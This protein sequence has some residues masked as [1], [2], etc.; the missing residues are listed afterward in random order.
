MGLSVDRSDRG[1]LNKDFSAR[2]LGALAGLS[3]K[4]E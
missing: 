2:E 3:A 4:G 1:G